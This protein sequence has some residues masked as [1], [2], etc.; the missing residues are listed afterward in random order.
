MKTCKQIFG[1]HTIPSICVVTPWEGSNTSDLGCSIFTQ[2]AQRNSPTAQRNIQVATKIGNFQLDR[3]A[4]S[5]VSIT[6]G[7]HAFAGIWWRC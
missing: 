2:V 3:S 6:P 7:F 4:P 1:T 5:N